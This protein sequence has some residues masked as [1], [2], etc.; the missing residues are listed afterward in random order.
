MLVMD[1]NLM[2]NCSLIKCLKSF[3]MNHKKWKN[4]LNQEKIK[5]TWKT[6]KKKKKLDYKYFIIY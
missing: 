3:K 1:S 2:F 5:L 4:N 6:N